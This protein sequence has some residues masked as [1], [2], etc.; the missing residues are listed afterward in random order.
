MRKVIASLF[1]SLDGVAER[2]DLFV[3]DMDDAMEDNL[4]RGIAEQD[5]VLLGR[6]TYDEFAGFWPGS[7]IEPFAS[8]INSVQKCRDID[9]A[10]TGV[11]EPR[12][13]RLH[14]QG[15][16]RRG[17]VTAR[18]DGRRVGG[19]STLAHGARGDDATCGHRPSAAS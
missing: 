18:R 11:E 12:R 16:Q 5:T 7:D 2:P 3:T 13:P 14:P 9:A 10:R 15:R 8:F 19:P 17:A 6:R 4:A 1:L